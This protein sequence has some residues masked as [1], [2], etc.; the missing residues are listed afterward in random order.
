[1]RKKTKRKRRSRKEE[2]ET[3]NDGK[4]NRRQTDKWT[5]QERVKRLEAES[6]RIG[7]KES[8]KRQKGKMDIYGKRWKVWR[9]GGEIA[10]V[11]VKGKRGRGRTEG[12]RK[13]RDGSERRRGGKKSGERFGQRKER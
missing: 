13:I 3:E 11:Y 5:T 1:M 12:R 2:T 10:D 6:G 9:E 8:R 4:E 7:R